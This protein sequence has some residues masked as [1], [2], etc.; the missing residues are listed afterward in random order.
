MKQIYEPAIIEILVVE[1]G[2]I[3][4]LSQGGGED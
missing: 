2:D 3:V 4:T 1:S